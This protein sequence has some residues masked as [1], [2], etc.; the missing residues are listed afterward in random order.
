MQWT[1]WQTRKV[2]LFIY[3]MMCILAYKSS[4]VFA[5]N[6]PL[7]L[8]QHLHELSLTKERLWSI[9]INFFSRIY[10]L[11]LD[12]G[13]LVARLC[14]HRGR[15]CACTRVCFIE[16]EKGREREREWGNSVS[17]FPHTPDDCIILL[18]Q[19]HPW[20]SS[21]K[22][23]L[24]FWRGGSGCAGFRGSGSFVKSAGEQQRDDWWESKTV[25]EEQSHR[26]QPVL[27]CLTCTC[28]NRLLIGNQA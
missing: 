18:C 23:P 21:L 4:I 26:H 16:I 10:I 25:E 3:I 6:S 17:D 5:N 1:C 12:S 13:S 2:S 28:H 24:L 7:C 15:A 8:L 22:A 11:A 19:S 9:E 14:I 20:R 27:I